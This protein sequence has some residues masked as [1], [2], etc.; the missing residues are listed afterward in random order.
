METTK[1]KNGGNSLGAQDGTGQLKDMMST[2]CNT[3]SKA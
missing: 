3:P 1:K 2:N